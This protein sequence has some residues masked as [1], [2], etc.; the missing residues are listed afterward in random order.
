M[1]LNSTNQIEAGE[2]LFKAGEHSDTV[3]MVLKGKVVLR[4]RGTHVT[5]MAGSL[6]GTEQ[7]DGSAS[8]YDCVASEAASVY[9]VAQGDEKSLNA[10]MAANKDYNGI[11][12]YNHVR[13][14]NELS[15][16]LMSMGEYTAKICDDL[17]DDYD[18][19]IY[20]AK[21]ND[22]SANMLPAILRLD[23]YVSEVDVDI[24]KLTLYQEYAKIP[25]DTVKAF[26]SPSTV[27]TA[28]AVKDM[29]GIIGSIIE[30]CE[31]MSD[32]LERA[33]ALMMGAADSSLYRNYLMLGIDL[34]KKGA[35]TSEVDEK[36]EKFQSYLTGIKAL[37]GPDTLRSWNFDEAALQEMKEAYLSGGDFRTEDDA[38]GA[39][40][41]SAIAETI[42]SLTDS[43]DQLIKF[44]DYPE[45]RIEPFRELLE[46]YIALPDR[47][48]NDDE[49]RSIRKSLTEHFY[50]LYARVFRA[51]ITAPKVP[52]AAELLLDYGYVSERLLKESQLVELLKIRPMKHE[53]PC[54]VFT[55]K[56]WLMAVF[57]GEKEP[58]KND[59][60]QDY[61]EA[62]REMRK[63]GVITEQD[64]KDLANNIDKK[65]EHEIQN[66]ITHGT[67]VVNGQLM[68]SIP[69]LHAEQ[70]IG[71]VEKAYISA[72]RI[73]E[74]VKRL[75]K[76]DFSV[77]HREALFV[78][79][80]AGIEREWEMKQVLPIFILYPTVGENVIM[81]Q[82]I[83]GRKRD[84]EGRFFA[85]AFSY[86]AIDDMMM[87]AFGQ[88]RWSLC[89]TIQGTNWN[90]LQ[91]R[92]LTS[93]YADYIQ[94]YR[95]NH[96]LSDE[97]KEK[98]KLQIQRGRNNMREVFTQDYVIWM[99]AE[100]AG[101]IR[102]NKVAREMLATYCPF[103]MDIKLDHIR[104]PIFEDA[105][106]RNT[107]ERNKKVKELDLRYKA[108]ESKGVTI[109]PQLT[110]TLEFYR[111][112]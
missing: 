16:Q 7:A 5:A 78:D 63:S 60:G 108:L 92:S 77:F 83:T 6:L 41:E 4:S 109:P 100:A 97:A 31:G 48:S 51:T 106:A 50:V 22:C 21:Q 98:I 49:C 36:L 8:M 32:Y 37:I 1:K 17:K 91:I 103:S 101:A 35:D 45:D 57:N 10:L 105:F 52:K 24:Q 86:N 71:S 15:K 3:Y 46:K 18:K 61:T 54:I 70:F 20:I 73:N 88:F 112:L 13:I 42:T 11:I 19:Y 34:K 2:V 27:L 94:F 44:A 84:T 26:Y 75:L 28:A 38:S 53:D 68:T 72:E 47:E 99:K 93:E 111:D 82:E 87:K 12:V 23:R 39:A 40:V 67:R 74:S 64:E 102:L 55:M 9:A 56:D 14:L 43:F 104:Q 33:F 30:A 96:D 80:A 81:W 79:E 85:P 58:S 107:R 90:N 59:M 65:L 76:V 89:K 25:Y 29:S 95:K 62:L 66:V 110:A 69:I